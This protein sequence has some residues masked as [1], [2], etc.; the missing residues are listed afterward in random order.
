MTTRRTAKAAE[1]LEDGELSKPILS[2]VGQPGL[3][4]SEVPQCEEGTPGHIQG[5]AKRPETEEEHN[6]RLGQA[7]GT[8]VDI[9]HLLGTAPDPRA[10]WPGPPILLRDTSG[11]F[12]GDQVEIV[13]P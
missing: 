2:P 10:N 7:A 3:P 8:A 12:V 6:A 11:R 5:I 9:G 13:Q 4:G 1:P